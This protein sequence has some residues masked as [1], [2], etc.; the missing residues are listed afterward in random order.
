MHLHKRKIAIRRDGKSPDL[1]VNNKQLQTA[2]LVYIFDDIILSANASKYVILAII[3]L[4][5]FLPIKFI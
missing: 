1:K 3:E 2:N 4:K 5:S